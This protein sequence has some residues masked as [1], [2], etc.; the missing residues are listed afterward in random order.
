MPTRLRSSVTLK[1]GGRWWW[2]AASIRSRRAVAAGFFLYDLADHRRHGHR[3]T[4][5]SLFNNQGKLLY[6]QRV[7]D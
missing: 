7:A 2:Q 5:L 4:A 3:P 1:H 6:S